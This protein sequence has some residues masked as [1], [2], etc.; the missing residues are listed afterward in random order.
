MHKVGKDEAL[1][2]AA[3]T[4]ME[5]RVHDIQLSKQDLTLDEVL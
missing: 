3:S 2:L 5:Q 4:L 1:P